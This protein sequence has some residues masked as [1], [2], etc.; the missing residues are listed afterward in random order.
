M[1]GTTQLQEQHEQCAPPAQDGS[2]TRVTQLN[3]GRF[4]M[5]ED[6][7]GILSAS[8]VLNGRGVPVSGA[9]LGNVG[10]SSGSRSRKKEPP[11]RKVSPG[12]KRSPP[13]QRQDRR[14]R[15]DDETTTRE[16]E[17]KRSGAGLSSK[18]PKHPEHVETYKEKDAGAAASGVR[19]GA[20]LAVARLLAKH[21]MAKKNHVRNS[22]HALEQR[23]QEPFAD[24]SSRPPAGS[25][26]TAS[27]SM[28]SSQ[29]RAL[30]G[31][32]ST[33]SGQQK[34]AFTS[35]SQSPL[36]LLQ[37]EMS[38]QEDSG[39]T[40]PDIE[41]VLK[42]VMRDQE[43]SGEAFESAATAKLGAQMKAI[44]A[45]AQHMKGTKSVVVEVDKR[46]NV[47]STTA[48]GAPRAAPAGADEDLEDDPAQFRAAA[49]SG[50]RA[51]EIPT[52]PRGTAEAG[53]R[54]TTRSRA[55][56]DRVGAEQKPKDY[57]WS[58]YG[59]GGPGPGPLAETTS[60]TQELP[61]DHFQQVGQQPQPP[62]AARSRS[63]S[64]SGGRRGARPIPSVAQM[65]S[66]VLLPDRPS[67]RTAPATK[68]HTGRPS[69]LAM[70][71]RAEES[72]ARLAV[73][74]PQIPSPLM[75][76]VDAEHHGHAEVDR[77]HDSTEEE[78]TQSKRGRR[79]RQLL[80]GKATPRRSPRQ[81][82][83]AGAAESAL[84]VRSHALYNKAPPHEQ[85]SPPRR[86]NGLALPV[87]QAPPE[88]EDEAPPAARDD[89]NGAAAS[90]DSSERSGLSTPRTVKGLEAMK[91]ALRNGTPRPKPKRKVVA[92]A[93]PMAV[94]VKV[95]EVDT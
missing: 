56:K 16:D 53:T 79:P 61:V 7:S 23:P 27:N 72:E 40:R 94:T 11:R 15:R 59:R 26:S 1:S 39:Y 42:Q 84:A 88:Q 66:A 60:S 45:A 57:T 29:K 43:T 32:S 36:P 18:L 89:D 10:G 63:V 25:T 21:R 2:R 82:V 62:K 22:G 8:A 20:A 92:G 47:L 78:R 69:R 85:A 67:R 90:A 74:V 52:Q 87:Q 5:H 55:S 24:K 17:T 77:H 28:P 76:R 35:H 48:A 19:T 13:R 58:N 73:P 71:H 3:S 41:E 93:G 95:V 65:P 37:E 31:S 91:G 33:A 46:G 86:G 38:G 51:G 68:H 50:A 30:L 64:Q 54:S 4:G 6:E 14:V 83:A 70:A 12:E 9:S 44:L 75:P 80:Q 34:A 81:V 49:S